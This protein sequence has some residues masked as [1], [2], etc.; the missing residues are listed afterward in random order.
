MKT[1]TFFLGLVLAA[2]MVFQPVDAQN[3]LRKI[4]REST[5]VI[6]RSID[7]AFE[8]AEKEEQPAEEQQQEQTRQQQGE[9]AGQQQQGDDSRVD[10]QVRAHGYCS[11]DSLINW[12]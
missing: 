5:K 4:K 10:R 12:A 11:S 1:T 3:P 7:K 9:A 6:N 2:L 8:E